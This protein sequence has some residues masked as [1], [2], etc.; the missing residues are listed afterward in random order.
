VIFTQTCAGGATDR[1]CHRHAGTL[2]QQ[3]RRLPRTLP[4]KA[5]HSFTYRKWRLGA[6]EAFFRRLLPLGIRGSTPASTAAMPSSSGRFSSDA[7]SRPTALGTN[8]TKA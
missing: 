6:L 2:V 8:L 3:G 5:R 7:A 1:T 4:E